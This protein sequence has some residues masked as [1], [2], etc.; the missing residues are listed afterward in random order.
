MFFL[1]ARTMPRGRIVGAWIRDVSTHPGIAAAL[2]AL[3]L[4][5]SWAVAYAIG[6]ANVAAPHWFYVPVAVAASRFG[7][8]GAAL[9]SL[10]AA[11]L[12]GPLLPADVAAGV[13]QTPIDWGTRAAF[14]V[15]MGQFLAWLIDSHTRAQ[16][17]LQ[18]TRRTVSLLEGLLD[19]ESG[20]RA[21]ARS[22]VHSIEE[23]LSAG[24][25]A[26]VF[27]PIVD[28]RDGQVHGVEALSRF[29]LEPRRS[30]DYWFEAAW[31]TGLGLELE[32]S[33]LRAALRQAASLPD[34]L[35]VAVNL[36]PE[37]LASPEFREL[38]PSIAAERLTVEVT[39][40]A[41]VDDYERLTEPVRELRK[42]GGRLAIDDVG[43]GFASLR[44]I[45]RLDPD[46]IKLD[47]ELTRGVDVDRRR[48]A[49]ASGLVSFA[50]ELGC[51]VVSEGI[52]AHSELQT[53]Q[54]LGVRY[55]Q[56]YFLCVPTPLLDLDLGQPS[57]ILHSAQVPA[58]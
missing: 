44:H 54:T 11:I 18:A 20:D 24:G 2:I 7:H 40:H 17:D 58:G 22:V 25:P 38:L 8:R 15:A 39:E 49:L 51:W 30:P 45:L 37:A 43:S 27:Q 6:G 47:V 33:A 46:V 10:G 26:I 52:E 5:L 55:G 41:R 13:A 35:F 9:A 16:R 4:V 29:D 23:V 1:M 14:F 48:R 34:G 19:R 21:A 12:S 42:R 36:A 3:L 50:A 53:L 32:L 31:K 28:L 56:G 57:Q